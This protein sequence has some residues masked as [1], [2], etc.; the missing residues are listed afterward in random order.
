[1]IPYF[2][3]NTP[4]PTARI[5]DLVRGDF[6]TSL[7]AKAAYLLG[8]RHLRSHL[9]SVRAFD[10][11]SG[12][13]WTGAVYLPVRTGALG[14]ALAVYLG[15]ANIG[16][17]SAVE[18]VVR[19]APPAGAGGVSAPGSGALVDRGW[20][21]TASPFRTLRGAYTR[22]WSTGESVHWVAPLLPTEADP[23]NGGVTVAG[24]RI[25]TGA[26]NA[27]L[28]LEFSVVSTALTAICIFE[29]WIDRR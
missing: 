5:G 26:A 1:M 19:E 23:L 15:V 8:T 11:G 22:R 10:R 20:R 25:L 18:C 14:T 3:A 12:Q 9:Y 6:P 13:R 28:E 29:R 27:A 7:A 21:A 4:E 24:N 2:A 17:A 16:A